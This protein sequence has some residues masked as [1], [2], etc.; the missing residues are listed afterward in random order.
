MNSIILRTTMRLLAS[1]LL[2][3]S[4]FLLWRGH[5]EPGGGFAGGL[6]G[7][8]A[9]ILY[10]VALGPA[11]ARRLLRFPPQQV[12]AAG[13]AMAVASA[14][15]GVVL[16]DP[17]LTGQWWDLELGGLGPVKFGTP[18]VFDVGVYL[19]VVGVALTIMYA[20]MEED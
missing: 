14:V 19:A 6:T 5:N 17:F 10:A 12:I 3:A 11:D 18:F 4:L 20:L 9:A 15:V 1:L 2:L 13:L 16:G 7:A 8:A